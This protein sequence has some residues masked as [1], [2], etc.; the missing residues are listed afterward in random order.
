M[1]KSASCYKEVTRKEKQGAIRC[2]GFSLSCFKPRTS[3]LINYR[4]NGGG[5]KRGTTNSSSLLQFQM[6]NDPSRARAEMFCLKCESLVPALMNLWIW[7]RLLWFLSEIK[8]LLL[9]S[10]HNKWHL[11]GVKSVVHFITI[12][13]FNI[14]LHGHCQLPYLNV[15]GQLVYNYNVWYKCSYSYLWG[16]CTSTSSLVARQIRVD[17]KP[18]LVSN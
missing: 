1:S 4:R 18:P 10:K 11:S 15:L 14:L 17:F 8:P 9:T 7:L 6:W 5:R 2:W 3:Y 13:F 12:S 16:Y